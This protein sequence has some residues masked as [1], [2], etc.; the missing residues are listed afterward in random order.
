MFNNL[1][2]LANSWIFL[3]YLVFLGIFVFTIIFGRLFLF[4]YG[5]TKKTQVNGQ[6]LWSEAIDLTKY[7]FLNVKFTNNFFQEPW[8]GFNENKNEL[9]LSQKRLTKNNLL[10]LAYLLSNI[11]SIKQTRSENRLIRYQSWGLF[12]LLG[13]LFSL[14]LVVILLLLFGPR[15]NNLVSGRLTLVVQIAIQG[16]II[17]SWFVM[18]VLLIWWVT[19]HQKRNEDLLIIAKKLFSQVDYGNLKNYLNWQTYLLFSVRI[20]NWL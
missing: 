19:L 12:G 4:I 3:F 17:L 7:S 16:L 5:K 11:A 9:V 15:T 1:L 20:Y 6:K 18:V 2:S 10:V 13:L 8:L 14:F